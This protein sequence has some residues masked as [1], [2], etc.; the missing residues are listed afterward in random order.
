MTRTRRASAVRV[1]LAT[2]RSK[3]GACFQRAA[4]VGAAHEKNLDWITDHRHAAHGSDYD[5]SEDEATVIDQERGALCGH[6]YQRQDPVRRRDGSAVWKIVRDEGAA[7]WKG[8]RL[9]RCWRKV[10]DLCTWR[11][12]NL[13]HRFT[14]VIREERDVH[15]TG[16]SPK[17]I[18]TTECAQCRA[19]GREV[20][21]KAQVQGSVGPCMFGACQ[22]KTDH[23]DKDLRSSVPR[24][25]ASLSSLHITVGGGISTAAWCTNASRILKPR[26]H[27]RTG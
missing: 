16:Q 2:S 9:A 20:D 22:H 14:V 1:A 15:G 11:R 26:G 5:G 25:N 10:G 3:R 24:H 17:H 21:N 6:V 7:S 4:P 8:H 23:S 19:V 27:S 13:A 12:V 18:E